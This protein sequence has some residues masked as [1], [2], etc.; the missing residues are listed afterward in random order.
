MERFESDVDSSAEPRSTPRSRRAFVT[1]FGATATTALAGCGA[2]SGE[3]EPAPDEDVLGT[4]PEIVTMYKSPACGCCDAYAEY[5]S[6]VDS[7][8]VSTSE[9][10]D[11]SGVK[12]DFDV[13][14][15]LESC[16]TID[17]G[18]YVIEGHVPL[19]AVEKLATERPDVRG[20]ALPEMPA[21]SPGM[22]GSKNGKFTVYAFSEDREPTEFVRL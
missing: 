10:D 3:A 18:E 11:L 17:A 2:P 6:S 14:E 4:L 15:E 20:I 13:P 7:I 16:H 21:G 12:S 22:G 1:A 19:D 8:G 5:L 9:T